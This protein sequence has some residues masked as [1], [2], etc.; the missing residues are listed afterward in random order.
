[1]K[2]LLAQLRR[3]ARQQTQLAGPRYSPGLNVGAPNIEIAPLV[4][5][6]DSLAV[7][8]GFGRRTD[9]LRVGLHE[10]LKKA[11]GVEEIFRGLRHSPAIL[12][13]AVSQLAK[14][15]PDGAASVLAYVRR[16]LNGV[17]RHLDREQ[18]ALLARQQTATTDD[19][20]SRISRQLAD[21]WRVASAVREI[22]EFTESSSCALLTQN[23]LMIL[24][25]W[26]TGKTHSLCDVTRAR[27]QRRQPTLL[28]LAQHLPTGVEPLE[29]IC[30]MAKVAST[31][32][33]LLKRLDRAGKALG[34]RALIIVD[35]INEGDREL[36][37]TS[38]RRLAGSVKAY[39]HVGIVLSC[40][41]PF[42]LQ[43]IGSRSAADWVT[44]EHPGFGDAEF[45]A[46]LEFFQFYDIPL[47][48]VPFLDYEFSRPLF[49]KI[50]C[51]T[52]RDLSR[53]GKKEYLNSLASG[54]KGMTKVLEDFVKYVGRRIESDLGL[55]NSICWRIIK[56]DVIAGEMVGIAS[57]MAEHVRE[58]V[59]R[60][61]ALDAIGRVSNLPKPESRAILHRLLADGLLMESARWSDD[62]PQEVI[63]MPYQR[64]SDHLI[65]RHLL[66]DLSTASTAAIKRS[67]NRNRPLGRVFELDSWGGAFVMPG[68]ASAIML[69]FPE[70]VKTHLPA[71]QRELA[72]LLPK[73]K[74]RVWSVRGVFLTG[75]PWRPADSFSEQTDKLV[76]LFLSTGNGESRNEV[77]EVLVE[78]ATRPKH[79]LSADRLSRYVLGMTM[80]ERDTTWSEYLRKANDRSIVF[81]VLEWLKRSPLRPLN[82]A[83]AES[84]VVVVSLFL[85]T[86]RKSLRDQA[87]RALV[88]IGRRQPKVLF[89]HSIASLVSNDPYVPERVIAAAYGVAMNGWADP[90]YRAVQQELPSVASRLVDQMFVPG[91]PHP[92][93]HVLARGYALGVIALGRRVD[94]SCVSVRQR[95]FLKPPFAHL[96]EGFPAEQVVVEGDVEALNTAF[97][98]DFEN[99][100]LGR[101][102]SGRSNYDRAHSDYR[103][104]RKL[105]LWRAGQLGY[106]NERFGD[107][108]RSI[109]SEQAYTRSQEPERIERYGKKYT[110]IAYYEMYGLQQDRGAIA[111]WRMDRRCPDVDIDPSFP[112]EP[113]IWRPRLPEV[114][115]GAPTTFREWIA[116]GPTP[117][118]QRLY[119]M[120]RVNGIR[121]P[122][123]LVDGFVQQNHK[124]AR[125]VFTFLRGVFVKKT[126]LPRLRR[127]LRRTEYPGNFAVPD[128]AKDRYLYGGEVPWS[129]EY[130]P[131]LRSRRGVRLPARDSA[132]SEYRAGGWTGI[133]VEL[134]VR[135]FEWESHHSSLNTVSGVTVLAPALAESF[136]V[137]NHAQSGNLFDRRGAQ[138]TALVTWRDEHGASKSHLFYVRRSLLRRYLRRTRQQLIMIPW[139]ERTVHY[140]A[141][142]RLRHEFDDELGAHYHIHKGLHIVDL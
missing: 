18:V 54:Q 3:I 41:R 113:L 85:T 131:E 29:A 7:D 39:Q 91:A 61:E 48:Q 52:V 16:V 69:E 24:G 100:T 136:D 49:L 86:T 117:D 26:G 97:R 128:L 80:P 102:V 58:Y 133:P 50:L 20:K 51:V 96:P 137:V 46:Q 125:Q 140:E 84:M 8:A 59:T 112:N 9:E 63:G 135:E 81:R 36:W 56:G 66:R 38:L 4:L 14:S 127:K 142:D 65:A 47:P 138:A 23:R 89:D 107:I 73:A 110:W 134:G 68:I 114:F 13:E 6:V 78:L 5:A 75:L 104:V 94:P 28:V 108:D 22:H 44:V 31:P 43:M 103:R 35:G 88:L 119:Q 95:A 90:K 12:L 74:R 40:R 87:T 121:G 130:A 53:R 21:V 129:A 123:V 17:T 115:D 32:T 83:A 124:D 11:G 15:K 141:L 92:T 37:R 105:V 122:W 55:Q 62:G 30:R 139:G 42:N 2:P 101:L 60:T 64:F 132:F 45:D 1:M 93:R 111:D 67:F 116:T 19:Q 33:R 71:D 120:K 109:S 10:A 118:F 57:I 79:P 25:E 72:Y 106:T 27:L 77:L 70:R 76:D 126:R 99:Y 82:V 98:M 34:T